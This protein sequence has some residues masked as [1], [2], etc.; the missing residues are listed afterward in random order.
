V[1]ARGRRTEPDSIHARKAV[2]GPQR[3]AQHENRP[4]QSPG[5]ADV[6]Q[7]GTGLHHSVRRP[8]R[9]LTAAA[10]VVRT[11]WAITSV[12]WRT[13]TTRSPASSR[14]SPILCRP[15]SA[16]VEHAWKSFPAAVALVYDNYN[17]FVI[18]FGPTT[19]PS[20]SIFSL[21]CHRDGIS[22]CF[23][24][25]GPDLPDPTGMLRGS[26]MVVKLAAARVPMQASAG[27]LSLPDLRWRQ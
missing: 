20:D 1:D 24:Q 14:S 4:P 15:S 7:P 11:T 12:P 9:R 3:H 8:V 22:L 6:E 16:T 19:R 21:A 10:R 23:L 25:H 18:G 26:G 17:F 13:P 5:A 27:R 2:S